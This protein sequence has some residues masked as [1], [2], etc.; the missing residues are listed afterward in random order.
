MTLRVIFL[1][2]LGNPQEAS[3]GQR[4]RS[5]AFEMDDGPIFLKLRIDRVN[6]F[7]YEKWHRENRCGDTQSSLFTDRLT[8]LL[9]AL[10]LLHPLIG[11]MTY[12]NRTRFSSK[13]AGQCHSAAQKHS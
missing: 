10:E 5:V 8:P 1:S 12:E 6:F 3:Q 4:A 13:V 2:L 7:I 11:R 9:K